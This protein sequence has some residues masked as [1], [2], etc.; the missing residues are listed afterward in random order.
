MFEPEELAVV[1]PAS[2]MTDPS[3]EM[4]RQ[5]GQLVLPRETVESAMSLTVAIAD[6]LIPEEPIPQELVPNEPMH[7]EDPNE[8]TAQERL[9]RD[10]EQMP[11]TDLP[12]SEEQGLEG[13]M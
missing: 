13:Y 9:I 12:L 6:K 1:P 10:D 5:D 7:E 3:M 11:P 2:K 8:G 4:D